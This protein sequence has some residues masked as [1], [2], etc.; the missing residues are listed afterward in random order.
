[1]KKPILMEGRGR[2]DGAAYGGAA[3]E[4]AAALIR[5]GSASARL[6]SES[7]ITLF[8]KEHRTPDNTNPPG[9]DVSAVFTRLLLDNEDLQALSGVGSL[10]YFSSCSMTEAY[11]K[12]LLRTMEGPV[13][14][15]A[16]TVRHNS[17]EYQRPVPLE[18]FE[19]PPFSLDNRQVL[20]TL[21]TMA[22]TEGYG[23]IATTTT[24]LSGVY[25]Y[26]TKHLEAGHAEMLA[27]WFDVGQAENP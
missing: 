20:D 26:S 11:A 22:V 1:M 25:L 12:I 16:E 3:A 4:M 7:E 2:D 5:D 15:I 24:S 19:R 9:E 8:L 18:F 21:A 27:E 10:W 23:D 14:L 6:V 13:R 17:R